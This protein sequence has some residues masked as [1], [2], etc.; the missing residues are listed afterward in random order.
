MD[1]IRLNELNYDHHDTKIL[2]DPA[3]TLMLKNFLIKSFY[4]ND[5]Q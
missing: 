3:K 1:H 4:L 5:M 2:S